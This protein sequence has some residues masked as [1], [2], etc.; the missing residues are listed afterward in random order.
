MQCKNCHFAYSRTAGWLQ[1]HKHSKAE[2]PLYLITATSPLYSSFLWPLLQVLVVHVQYFIIITR[3]DL[4]WP[5]ML[6]RMQV[7][8]ASITGIASRLVF[9]PVCM[10]TACLDPA[11]QATA[12]VVTYLVLPG[13]QVVLSLLLGCIL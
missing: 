10:T 7:V 9:S 8:L 4:E 11:G 6:Q 1:T 13:V 2:G 5:Q 3:M 12:E